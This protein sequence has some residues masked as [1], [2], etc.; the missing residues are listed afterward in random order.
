MDEKGGCITC[1]ESLREVLPMT[2]V[3]FLACPLT[4]ETQYLLNEETIEMLPRGSLIVNVGRGPLVEHKAILNALRSGQVGGFASDVG[5]GHPTKP[6]EPWDPQDE[7][8]LEDNV[9]FT[10]HIAGYTDVAYE[11]MAVAFVDALE[12]IRKGH[13]PPIWTNRNT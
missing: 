6:S 5:V 3:L 8:S 12:C 4:A 13:P 10:P 1:A 7:L 2:D 9:L 11:K